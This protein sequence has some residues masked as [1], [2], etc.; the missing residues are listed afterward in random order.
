MKR[1]ITF[2]FALMFCF[3]MKAQTSL[4]EAVDFTS[5]GLNGEEIHLF[6]ILDNGQ[7]A[8][9]EFFYSTSSGALTYVNK[10]IES[11]QY[12]GCNENDVYYMQISRYDDEAAARAWCNEYGIM[13]PTIHTE[14]EGDT[15]DQICETYGIP[16]Y[17]TVILI[18]PDRQIVLQDIWPVT[19]TENIIDA[20]TPFGIEEHECSEVLPEVKIEINKATSISIEA[21]FTPN[22]VCSSYYFILGEGSSLEEQDTPLEQIIK[23]QGEKETSKTTYKWTDLTPET[24]YNIYV[25]PMNFEDSASEINKVTLS[26]TAAW[27]PAEVELEVEL[28]C[29][30][31]LYTKATPNDNTYEYHYGVFKKS[32]YESLGEETITVILLEDGYPLFEVDEWNWTEL[33]P[34]TDYYAIA[35]GINHDE[36]LG[37][38]TIIPFRT[39]FESLGEINDYDF[40]INPNPAQDVVRV[41]TVNGQQST[42]RIYNTLGML[43]EEIDVDSV[44]NSNE[45]EI[46]VSDW[47][48]GI[49]FVRLNDKVEKLIVK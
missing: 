36:V 27:G 23:E 39:E 16:S 43:I 28:I 15:G 44:T 4:T 42:I 33:I 46:N 13:F 38:L 31:E 12:F 22:F 7:Y 30:T 34:K 9:I 6:D 3:N 8:L 45:I 10:M 49:Y 5:V 2:I 20:L 40:T 18:A 25:L 24:L 37:E 26:T 11:Y 48:K 32:E 47:D 1:T 35:V 41:S 19:S 21:E 29:E 14:S 17:P